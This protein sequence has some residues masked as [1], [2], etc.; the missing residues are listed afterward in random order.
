MSEKFNTFTFLGH[1][2]IWLNSD[3]LT[4]ALELYAI[5]ILFIREEVSKLKKS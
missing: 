1:I 2:N 3:F 5:R 4:Q